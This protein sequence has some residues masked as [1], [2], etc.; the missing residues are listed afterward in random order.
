MSTA[1]DMSVEVLL[2]SENP[3]LVLKNMQPF[4]DLMMNYE[5]ALMEIET[6]L[7]VLNT[8]FTLRHNRNP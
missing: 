7:K 8:E 3:E 1:A 6:K 4:I 2:N 5:C